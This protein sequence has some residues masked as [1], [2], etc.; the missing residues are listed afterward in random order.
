VREGLRQEFRDWG[1][2]KEDAATAHRA[3]LAT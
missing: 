2:L 1:L 3:K